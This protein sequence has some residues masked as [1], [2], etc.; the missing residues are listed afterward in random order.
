MIGTGPAE[1]RPDD[2]EAVN[3][4]PLSHPDIVVADSRLSKRYC[5]RSEFPVGR[6]LRCSNELSRSML[7]ASIALRFQTHDSAPAWPEGARYRA[8][9][10]GNRLVLFVSQT[11]HAVNL[12]DARGS[13]PTPNVGPKRAS[14]QCRRTHEA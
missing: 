4:I 7:A 9:G 6:R 12:A 3:A 10:R 11:V 2:A 5:V 14:R 1:N 8:R 13:L